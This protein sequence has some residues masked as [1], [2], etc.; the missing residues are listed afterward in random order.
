MQQTNHRRYPG[1]RPFEA[2]DKDLF[3][4]RT[5]DIAD[6][7]DLISIE[8][9]VVLYGKS[10]YGK[11]SLLNAGIL[12]RL[13]ANADDDDAPLLPIFI[14]LTSYTEGQKQSP[15]EN[16]VTQ[17]DQNA[18]LQSETQFLDNLLA[19]PTLWGGLC[20]ATNANRPSCRQNR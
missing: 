15:I 16:V 3:F 2:Q 7:C 14:R 18:P 17:L 4:G 10:G 1:V 13:Q 5:Q 19:A 6:L 12:P 20:L 8:K 9:L 11:S